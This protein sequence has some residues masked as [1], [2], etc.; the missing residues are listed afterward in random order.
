VKFFLI[1]K[2]LTGIPAASSIKFAIV[3]IEVSE[4]NKC[5][6]NCKKKIKKLILA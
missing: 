1:L 6:F 2:K 4:E 3:L 5:Q